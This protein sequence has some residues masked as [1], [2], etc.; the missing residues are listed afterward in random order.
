MRLAGSVS[1]CLIVLSLFATTDARGSDLTQ[2]AYVVSEGSNELFVVDLGTLT[3]PGSVDTTIE[4][5]HINENHMAMVTEDGA[6]VYVNAT[7]SDAVIAIDAASLQVVS[8]I[9]VGHHPSHGSIRPGSDEL[10]IVNEESNTVSVI[11]TVT[12]QVITTISHRSFIVPH[13]VRFDATGDMAYIPNIGGNQISIVDASQYKVVGRLVAGGTTSGPCSD[14]PCGF[15][16]AQIDPNGIL[17]AAHNETAQILIYDTKTG[18]RLPDAKTSRRPWVAFVDPIGAQALS[19]YIV[20]NFGDATVTRVAS[21]SQVTSDHVPLGD[22]E[23]Y[24][25]NYSPFAPNEAF[26]MNRNKQEVVVM[27]VDTG[28]P[29]DVIATGGTAETAATS[30]DGRYLVLPLSTVNGSDFGD[31]V[32]IEAATHKIVK[33]FSG[34]GHYPWSAAVLPGGQNYCH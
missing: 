10:W 4:Q 18:T 33:R 29:L 7:H 14:D 34:V 9:G 24:G 6:K 21:S 20:P 27:S 13:H 30:I 22:S 23:T 32:I 15:A 16:D 5:G 1:S 3:T 25:V 2:R 28:R 19:H 12:D 11:D 31:V 17:Y 26:V 8:V